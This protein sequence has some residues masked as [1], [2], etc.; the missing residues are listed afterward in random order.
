MNEIL[1]RLLWLLA[2]RSELT[3][4]LAGIEREILISRGRLAQAQQTAEAAA[5]AAQPP[6]AAPSAPAS[7]SP[8]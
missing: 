2:R 5:A 4:E 6:T 1:Q 7:D 3:E 8:T